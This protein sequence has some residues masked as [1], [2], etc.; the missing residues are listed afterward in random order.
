MSSLLA[1]I[2][3]PAGTYLVAFFAGLITLLIVKNGTLQRVR[4]LLIPVALWLTYFAS[5]N[6]TKVAESANGF[7]SSVG[8]TSNVAYRQ[9]LID[10]FKNRL[11][12]S[13]W[14]G[15]GFTRSVLV[16]TD[17]SFLPLHNDFFTIAIGGGYISVAIFLSVIL[18]SNGLVL[19][20]VR[21]GILPP[22]D[23]KILLCLL[24][25]L[26]SYVA[27]SLVNPISMKAHNTLIFAGLL[28]AIFC[29]TIKHRQSN[30]DYFR[31]N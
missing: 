18:L 24:C 8:R 2:T 5:F 10:Q 19:K 20:A 6:L 28:Y 13:P 12:E 11:L 30:R 4:I 15:S 21:S 25:S 31:K 29:I 17:I 1:M 23:Y 14:V 26:N 9:F 7:Y 22:Q 3:Y 16:P 27:V